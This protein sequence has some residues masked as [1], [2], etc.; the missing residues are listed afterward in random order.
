MQ[1]N[2][3][4]H[5]SRHRHTAAMGPHPRQQS[6]QQSTNIIC[7]GSTLSK[8]EKKIFIT[9]NMAINARRIDDDE[10]RRRCSDETMGIAQPTG[11]NSRFQRMSTGPNDVSNEGWRGGGG[12]EGVADE[13]SVRDLVCS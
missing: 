8:L 10:R 2:L 1:S 5:G 13:L 9:S 3:M 12:G 7:D 11:E 6:T 4:D